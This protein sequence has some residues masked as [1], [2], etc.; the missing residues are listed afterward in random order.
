MQWSIPE[1]NKQGGSGHTFLTTGFFYS[2]TLPLEIPDKSKLHPWKL[3]KIVFYI[4]W[5]FQDQKPRPLENPHNFFLVTPRNST[6]PWKIPY[7][8]PPFP[9]FVFFSGIDQYK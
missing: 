4:V 2:F 5:K 3:F 9:L 6:Y 1:K 7:P 8:Q